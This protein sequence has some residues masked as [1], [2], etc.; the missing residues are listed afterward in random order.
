MFNLLIMIFSNNR[1]TVDQKVNE[2]KMEKM[3]HEDLMDLS[4]QMEHMV[5]LEPRGKLEERE[6]QEF[7]DHVENLVS[8]DQEDQVVHLENKGH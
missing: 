1:V 2:E 8:W 7:L 4:V 3:V 5:L 6:P